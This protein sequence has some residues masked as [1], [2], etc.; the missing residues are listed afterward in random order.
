MNISK[1]KYRNIIKGSYERPEKYA[2]K[3]II[4]ICFH[5]KLGILN[6]KRCNIKKLIY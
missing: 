5:I 2:S 6:E 4:F 3:K 1:E